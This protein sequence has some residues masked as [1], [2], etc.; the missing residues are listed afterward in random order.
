MADKRSTGIEITNAKG[1]FES[2]TSS[3]VF[4]RDRKKVSFQIRK[5]LS[6]DATS[7]V[8][9]TF[10]LEATNNKENWVKV[11][12]SE[13]SIT[14]VNDFLIEFIDPAATYYRIKFEITGVEGSQE[15]DFA[16]WINY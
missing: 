15:S 1:V 3:S 10:C 14:G 6:E 11:E 12:D 7:E 13:V 9:G 4:C 16:V 5:D 2:F 8:E